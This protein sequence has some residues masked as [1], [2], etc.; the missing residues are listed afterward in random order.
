MRRY[1]QSTTNN[2]A[3][4]GN[5]TGFSA[6]LSPVPEPA[7]AEP[8]PCEMF[9]KGLYFYNTE[10]GD[11]DL[12]AE[13]GLLESYTDN[14]SITPDF[15][16]TKPTY[17]WSA[18]LLG[19]LCLCSDYTVE[20]DVGWSDEFPPGY[21][22][23]SNEIFIY[24]RDDNK[25]EAG[26]MTIIAK[27]KD[28]TG[29]VVYTSNEI[30]LVITSASYYYNIGSGGGSYWINLPINFGPYQVDYTAYP[31]DSYGNTPDG[32]IQFYPNSTVT[33]LFSNASSLKE[34]YIYCNDGGSG[35][36]K[37]NNGSTRYP[38]RG[39]FYPP[40]KGGTS[41]AI[42]GL[43]KLELHSD[44]YGSPWYVFVK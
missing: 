31:P 37:V 2:I 15:T 4:K 17:Q 3:I 9:P 25:D 16:L 34:I 33:F 30:Y 10:S 26:V 18:K 12:T 29:V 40:W 24:P 13:A 1:G 43:T 27:L 21:D 23:S 6:F 5:D 36:F 32:C 28:E 14:V 35:W 8:L 19:E 7:V 44:G 22:T 42:S 11:Y 20:F 41:V 39:A 38:Q